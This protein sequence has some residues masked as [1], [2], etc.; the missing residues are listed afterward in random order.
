[1]TI[2]AIRALTVS[3]LPNWLK[4]WGRLIVWLQPWD[5]EV[6]LAERQHF[7]VNSFRRYELLGWIPWAASCLDNP[8]RRGSC[9]DWVIVCFPGIWITEFLMKFTGSLRQKH[10]QQRGSCTSGPHCSAAAPVARRG[11]W[12]GTGP[13][14]IPKQGWFAS[15]RTMDTAMWIRFTM[16]STFG[17]RISGC[18]TCRM[19]QERSRIPLK[20]DRRG[21]VWNGADAPILKS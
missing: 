18:P 14:R 16:M 20:L 4:V 8:T 12:R 10:T 3:W 15:F 6:L 13:G 17:K 7:C 1:M 11:W 9:A 21:L 2:P 19:L 5:Q